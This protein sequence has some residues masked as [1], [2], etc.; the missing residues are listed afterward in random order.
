MNNYRKRSYRDL[1]KEVFLLEH[2]FYDADVAK[3]IEKHP[4]L[5][6]GG[7]LTSIKYC[8][9]H[10]NKTESRTYPMLMVE[11]NEGT[12]EPVRSNTWHMN[13]YQG[14][15]MLIRARKIYFKN[16]YGIS[17]EEKE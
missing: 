11:L 14:E 4:S 17:K 1:Q 9:I 3:F 7:D 5:L 13:S 16:K 12:P 8:I 15:E 2:G 6:L 10:Y